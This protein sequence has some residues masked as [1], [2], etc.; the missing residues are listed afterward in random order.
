M[1][2]GCRKT[3]LTAE[4]MGHDLRGKIFLGNPHFMIFMDAHNVKCFNMLCKCGVC[5]SVFRVLY[6]M[7]VKQLFVLCNSF[8][9]HEGKHFHRLS[10][11]VPSLALHT[12][13]NKLAIIH[14]HTPTHRHTQH[15]HLVYI[16]HSARTGA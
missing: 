2:V 5:G 16:S 1:L 10:V 13:L 7:C 6:M 12:T 8:M 11:C 4:Q 9:T 14:T 3:C 15:T